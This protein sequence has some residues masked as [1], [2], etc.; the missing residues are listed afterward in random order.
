MP[1]ASSTRAS[2]GQVTHL[3]G[4]PTGSSKRRARRRKTVFVLS[5]GGNLGAVQ[6]GQLQAVFEAG[7]RPDALVGS[8]VGALNATWVAHDPTPESV[9]RLSDLW[10]SIRGEQLFGSRKRQQLWRVLRGGSALHSG[11]SLRSFLQQHVPVTDLADCQVPVHVAATDLLSG[12]AQFFDE[13]PA[14]PILGASAAIPGLLPPVPVGGRL[15]IDGGVVHSVPLARAAELGATHV[16]VLHAG[17]PTYEPKRPLDHVIVAFAAARRSRIEGDLAKFHPSVKVT[18]LSVPG[19]DDGTARLDDGTLVST[20]RTHDF[21][22]TAEL[23]R[24]GRVTAAAQ[25]NAPPTSGRSGLG[26]LA[27]RL[28]HS[29][30]RPWHQGGGPAA[31]PADS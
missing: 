6:V 27:W 26:E 17:I 31:A 4:R 14:V 23:M 5:A 3:A 1:A 18:W 30:H 11:M 10:L 28:R 22:H 9:A 21:T 7:L 16:V 20:L 2:R 12:Q 13:G 24:L 29:V 25:L 15:Y 19:I 8:S